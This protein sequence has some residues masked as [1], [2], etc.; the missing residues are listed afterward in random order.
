MFE[1]ITTIAAITLGHLVVRPISKD[2]GW[3]IAFDAS[4]AHQVESKPKDQSIAILDSGAS[5]T[6][7]SY[8]SIDH[9]ISRIEWLRSELA[10]YQNLPAGWD[11]EGSLPADPMHISAAST[12]LEL[13]PAG[14]PLPKPM[15]SPDGELGLYWKGDRWFADAVIEDETHFSLFIRSLEHGNREVFV[16]SIGIDSGA[17]D[18]IK[19]AFAAV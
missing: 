4:A 14:I 5:V 11:G 12:L 17:S 1:V 15:L 3:M 10:S 6:S 9:V 13:I 16:D 19:N 8:A 18:A 7:A 2:G